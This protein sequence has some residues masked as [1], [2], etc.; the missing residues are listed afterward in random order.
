MTQQPVYPEMT[1]QLR[2]MFAR[3]AEAG[4]LPEV[5][6]KVLALREYIIRIARVKTG[7]RDLMEIKKQDNPIID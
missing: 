6:D 4:M 2:T 3:L 5:E 7:G 1:N